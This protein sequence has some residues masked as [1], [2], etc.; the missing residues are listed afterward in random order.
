MFVSLQALYIVCQVVLCFSISWA[1]SKFASASDSYCTV[2]NVHDHRNGALGGA[3]PV[4]R[5]V[6]MYK[7]TIAAPN[8]LGSTRC[9]F[10]TCK[11][12]NEVNVIL[13]IYNKQN[14][15][16]NV[17]YTLCSSIAAQWSSSLNL[18]TTICSSMKQQS[19]RKAMDKRKGNNCHEIPLRTVFHNNPDSIIMLP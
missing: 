14:V 3:H 18:P 12:M 11:Y 13:Y 7:S 16:N 17:W 8:S 6:A 15:Y 1:C 5:L 10:C 2:Y 4:G 9:N 19:L